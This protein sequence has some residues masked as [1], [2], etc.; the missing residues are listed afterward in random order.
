MKVEVKKMD[1]LTAAIK[2][3]IALRYKSVRRF[4]IESG[5]PQSTLVSALKKGFGGTSYD[6]VMYICKL[7]ELNPFDYSP[8]GQQNPPVTITSAYYEL[9]PIGRHTVD[10]IITVEL[11]R[12]KGSVIGLAAAYEGMGLE[13]FVSQQ[14]QAEAAEA[15]REIKKI[16]E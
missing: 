10:S 1:L 8:A 16:D 4:S 12:C 2:K 9:D 13:T 11:L 6:T 5:I 14:D 3:E 7:L 15:L